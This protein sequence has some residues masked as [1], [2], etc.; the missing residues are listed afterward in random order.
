MKP[1]VVI[2]TI[3]L[4]AT[5]LVDA[6][7]FSVHGDP[8]SPL[9]IVRM[10]LIYA[11]VHLLAI[12]LGLGSS[13]WSLRVAG[14]ATGIAL[15]TALLA[16]VLTPDN[17]I[18]PEYASVVGFLSADAAVA[19]VLALACRLAGYRWTLV[20]TD[21][22]GQV[23][24]ASG[25]M[26]FTLARLF[27]W[28]TVTAF[29]AALVAQADPALLNPTMMAFIF[30]TSAVAVLTAWVISTTRRVLIGL[31]LVI[32]VAVIEV[33][34]LSHFLF[35][36]VV[37]GTVFALYLLHVL[38]IAAWFGACRAVDIRIIR[39]HRAKSRKP[40]APSFP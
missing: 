23:R 2:V 11:Q 32:L 19:A 28:T 26:Q 15:L 9:I 4:V 3:L 39:T 22:S 25:P 29:T 24:V 1:H 40:E 18:T 27:G 31:A 16:P 38:F 7:A 12:W 17:E 34:A 30:V 37:N 20:E 5:V 33:M 6:A 21:A 10:A 13:D 35:G 8:T 14:L 36:G